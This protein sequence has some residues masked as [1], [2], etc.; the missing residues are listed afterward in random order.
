M[1][2][3]VGKMSETR[4]EVA[5]NCEALKTGMY[6]VKE[7]L[8]VASGAATRD[9]SAARSSAASTLPSRMVAMRTPGSS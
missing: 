9:A 8:P 2:T 3:V 4:E 1:G 5:E 6:G 7:V